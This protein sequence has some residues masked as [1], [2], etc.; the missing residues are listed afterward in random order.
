MCQAFFKARGMKGIPCHKGA[1]HSGD[2][3]I[4]DTKISDGYNSLERSL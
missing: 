3:D 1:L 2:G 4:S